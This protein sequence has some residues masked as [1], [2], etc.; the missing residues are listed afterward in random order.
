MED[1]DEGSGMV[2]LEDILVALQQAALQPDD[3]PAASALIERACGAKGNAL[4]VCSH[5]AVR[6]DSV[7][8]WRVVFG[9]ERYAD[10]ELEFI[11]DHWKTDERIPRV[12]RLGDG[13]LVPTRNLYTASERQT[14]PTYADLMARTDMRGGLHARLDVQD[15]RRAGS[16][17]TLQIVWALGES[18]DGDWSAAQKTIIKRL[19]PHLRHF[20]AVRQVLADT[21]ALNKSLTDLLDLRRIA[22]I[23]L[24]R[25]AKVVEANDHATALLQQK[26][27]GLID[28]GGYLRAS[29][30]PDNA[31]LQGLLAAALPQHGVQQG[32]AGSVT[33]GRAARSRLVVHVTPVPEPQSDYQV[34]GRVATLVFVVDP[35][36]RPLIDQDIVAAALNLTPAEARVTAMLASGHSVKAIADMTDRSQNTVR[37]QLKAAFRKQAVASQSDLV[38]K[39]LSLDGLRADG[40]R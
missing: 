3:W 20:A 40:D 12:R 16:Q 34:V 39:V 6:R 37:A 15:G 13:A 28:A 35:D 9:G 14:S 30:P 11:R 36:R 22:V 27:S 19:M 26:G 25:H 33:I 17:S 1:E 24:D 2:P 32:T 38:R 8:F 5:P 21:Q 4:M 7:C 18:V 31:D 23:Q 29:A 10:L